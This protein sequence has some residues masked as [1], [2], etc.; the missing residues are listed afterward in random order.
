M[1]GGLKRKWRSRAGNDGGATDEGEIGL[2][3]N[4]MDWIDEA[5]LVGQKKRGMDE[6]LEGD[7]ARS[8]ERDQC[9]WAMGKWK[10]AEKSW[11]RRPP[12][13]KG[14]GIGQ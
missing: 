11:W 12:W 5:K 2:G 10:G 14:E 8:T 1:G 7:L 9:L 4:G 3:Q 13:G 6:E